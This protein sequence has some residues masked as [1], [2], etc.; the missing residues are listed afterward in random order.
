MNSIINAQKSYESING[1]LIPKISLELELWSGKNIE[2]TYGNKKVINYKN[3]PVYAEL[4]IVK[5][6][7]E[8]NINAVW[9]DNFRKN[10]RNEL[11]EINNGIELPKIIKMKYDEIVSL[12]KTRNGCWDILTWDK[13]N[14]IHF[15]E[16]KE[17]KKD[18]IRNTQI[19]WLQSCLELGYTEN[20]FTIVEWKIKSVKKT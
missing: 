12:N 15:Y 13:E 9:V 6:L 3:Q 19:K 5:T 10:F 20:N 2:D 14:Q 8:K 18:K 7:K 17:I 16:L 4:Y 1:Y 11:P